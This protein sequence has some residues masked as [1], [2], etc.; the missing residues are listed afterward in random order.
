M[1]ELRVVS[2]QIGEHRVFTDARTAARIVADPAKL[3]LLW[4]MML[5]AAQKLRDFQGP[6][7]H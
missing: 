1:S 2:I 3:L 6:N 5:E 4:D 7:P